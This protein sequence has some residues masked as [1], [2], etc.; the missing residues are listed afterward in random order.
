MNV[1]PVGP[2]LIQFP[3]PG[4][5]PSQRARNPEVLEMEQENQRLEEE[6]LRIQLAKGKH[7]GEE[8]CQLFQNVP[9]PAFD[10]F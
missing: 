1:P 8:G 3:C 2:P 10:C 5:K 7:R 6:I 4:I 9:W